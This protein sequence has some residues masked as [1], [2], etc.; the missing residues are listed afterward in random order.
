MRTTAVLPVKDFGAAKQRLAGS[1]ASP[2]H[3]LSPK[4]RQALA[5]AMFCD[6]LT[7][8]SKVSRIDEVLVVTGGAPARR[9]ARD[10]GVRVVPDDEHGHNPAAL[11][12]IKAAIGTGADRALLVPGDCPGLDPSELDRLLSRLVA[13]PSVLIVPD[14]HGTGTNALVLTPPDVFTPSFGPGSCRRHL[15]AARAAQATAEVVGVPSLATDVDTPEDLDAL[16]ALLLVAERATAT[17]TR[18]ALGTLTL[19]SRC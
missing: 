5:E 6:V 9:I 15:E 3:G 8:L 11:A 19:L 18:E 2:T 4:H 1:G 10:R 16:E 14:R 13:V 12:G 17:A 7:A